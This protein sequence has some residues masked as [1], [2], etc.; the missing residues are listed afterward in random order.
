MVIKG[1]Y[2]SNADGAAYDNDGSSINIGMY[3]GL[4]IALYIIIFHTNWKK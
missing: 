1:R 4:A 3:L 2:K